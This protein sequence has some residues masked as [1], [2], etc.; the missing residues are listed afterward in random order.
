MEVHHHPDIH[1]KPK[2]WK[3]YF[4]EGFMI[5]VAVMLGFFAEG[6]RENIGDRQKE[7][8]YI[9]SFIKNLQNDTSNLK[10]TILE[11]QWKIKGLDTLLSLSFKNMDETKT[12]RLFYT[13]VSKYTSL[14]SVFISNDATM[15]QLKNA[16]GLRFV[17]Q[18]HVADSIANYDFAVRDIY[19]S[20]IPYSKAINDVMDAAQELLDDNIYKDSTYFKNGSF[21]GKT[22]PLLTSDPQKIKIFFNKVSYERGWTLN[23][24]NNL[25]AWLPFAI[26]LMDFLKKEYGA[27]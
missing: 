12:R 11:N 19:L 3:E 27:E 24:V 6:L 20:Q 25:E 9:A 4:L 17:R 21:T 14:T 18:N 1:H 13:Y 2:A 10:A 15:M 16:G 5:F 8:E 22:L 26:N 7:K 23:Y